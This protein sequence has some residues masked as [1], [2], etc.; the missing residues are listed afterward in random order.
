MFVTEGIIPVTCLYM[1]E[2]FHCS[3]TGILLS[4]KYAGPKPSNMTTTVRCAVAGERANARFAKA[5][6]APAAAPYFSKSL[7]L[8]ELVMGHTPALASFLESFTMLL[9]RDGASQMQGPHSPV[10]HAT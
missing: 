6:D 2:R 10:R 3:N 1:P 5:A 7:R 4:A 9:L 8:M